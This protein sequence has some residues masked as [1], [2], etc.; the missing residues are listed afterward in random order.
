MALAC[1]RVVLIMPSGRLTFL[2]T[3][4]SK[5]ALRLVLEAVFLVRGSVLGVSSSSLQAAISVED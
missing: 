2:G 4:E 5:S 3:G 1:F